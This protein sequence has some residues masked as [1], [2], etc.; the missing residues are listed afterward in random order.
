MDDA[1]HVANFVETEQLVSLDSDCTSFMQ[2]R[3]SV[4]LFWEQV[5]RSG[6]VE[7]IDHRIFSLG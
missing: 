4:S 3:G 2:I 1:G 7:I 6:H 5:S